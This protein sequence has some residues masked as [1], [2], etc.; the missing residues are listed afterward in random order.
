MG[1]RT[2]RLVIIVGVMACGR[3]GFDPQ[4]D[5]REDASDGSDAGDAACTNALAYD[6]VGDG[7]ALAPYLICNAA[8]WVDIVAHPESWGASFKLAADIDL[9]SIP[10][11]HH[12]IGT[13]VPLAPFTGV[14]DGD[15]HVVLN[16][17]NA[18]AG[19]YFGLFG[20]VSGAQA[21]IKN[22]A[23]VDAQ[24]WTGPQAGALVGYLEQGTVRN[25]AVIGSN[26]YTRSTGYANHRGTLIGETRPGSV[27][28]DVFG[29][30]AIDGNGGGVGGLIGH[31]EGSVTNCYYQHAGIV[32]DNGG[33]YVGG[34]VGWNTGP[35]SI[36]NCFAN[37]DVHGNNTGTVGLLVGTGTAPNNSYYAANRTCTNDGGACNSYGTGIDLV[38]TPDYFSRKANPPLTS[39][40]FTAVWAERTNSEPVLAWMLAF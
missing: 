5:E 31:H 11:P 24:L 39:W 18:A 9:S 37:V 29:S 13:Y 6:S 14:M 1:P 22:I 21:E 26:C 16:F 7:G 2:G 32:T 12:A 33:N 30:C 38:T 20:H 28:V 34:L 19:S 40:D 17:T 3:S 10:P 36:A 15:R 35:G 8:Q 4:R 25:A 23:L 27:V